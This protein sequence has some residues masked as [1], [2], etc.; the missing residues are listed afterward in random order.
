MRL[1]FP[2]AALALA[3]SNSAAYDGSPGE[4]VSAF[5]A[6]LSKGSANDAVDGLYSSNSAFKQKIQALTVLKQ[7]M[8]SV[9]ALFGAYL[10]MELVHEEQISPS[11]MRVVAIEKREIHPI[12]W[13]FYFYKPKE[14]WVISQAVFGDQFQNLQ[15]NQ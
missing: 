10:G 4:Q 8:A 2:L 3:C 7:Q 14:N 11:V 12:I 15:S 6:D 1:G 5:F 9:P 13:E